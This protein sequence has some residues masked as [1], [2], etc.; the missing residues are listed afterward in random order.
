MS[1]VPLLFSENEIRYIQDWLTKPPADLRPDST[2]EEVR[3]ISHRIIDE[4]IDRHLPLIGRDLLEILLW[5][6]AALSGHMW[7]HTFECHACGM[8]DACRVTCLAPTPDRWYTMGDPECPWG[9]TDPSGV[10]RAV[11]VL[12]TPVAVPFAADDREVA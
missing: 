5:M 4:A 11:W 9:R 10:D 8:H 12:L 3:A 2:D 6:R 1:A 7:E